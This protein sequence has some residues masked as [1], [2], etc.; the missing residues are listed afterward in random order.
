MVEDES[1]YDYLYK[2]DLAIFQTINYNLHI[3]YAELIL[4]LI[5]LAI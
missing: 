4:T 1:K 2:T 3:L 5:I